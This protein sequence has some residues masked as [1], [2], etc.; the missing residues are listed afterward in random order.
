MGVLS[1][2]TINLNLKKKDLCVG[3]WLATK[4]GPRTRIQMQLMMGYYHSDD[5]EETACA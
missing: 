3:D 2:M 5:V 1:Y 4:W